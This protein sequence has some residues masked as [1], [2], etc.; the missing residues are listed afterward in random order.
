MTLS[1]VADELAN[2]HHGTVL[3]A[4]ERPT[5][6][7]MLYLVSNMRESLRER[8]SDVTRHDSRGFY[9]RTVGGSECRGNVVQ[10]DDLG[11][12]ITGYDRSTPVFTESRTGWYRS[13]VGELR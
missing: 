3:L 13:T 4:I 1:A 11:Y 12:A 6:K 5:P 7:N 2:C 10:S 8:G 9:F